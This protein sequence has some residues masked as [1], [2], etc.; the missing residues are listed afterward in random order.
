MEDFNNKVCSEDC[1]KESRKKDSK[2]RYNDENQKRKD[3]SLE[4]QLEGAV[5]LIKT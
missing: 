4:I 3:N 5:F 1:K 2:K